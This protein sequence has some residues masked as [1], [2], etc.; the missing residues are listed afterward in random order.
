MKRPLK[1]WPYLTPLILCVILSAGYLTRAQEEEGQESQAQEAAE[2][3]QGSVDAEGQTKGA[4]SGSVRSAV[5]N[6]AELARRES[7][8]GVPLSEPKAIRNPGPGPLPRRAA[9][10]AISEPEAM[11]APPEAPQVASPAPASSFKAL[12]DNGTSVPP[13]THGA[14]GP[15]HLMVTHNTQLRIQTKTGG[16]LS[17]VTLNEFWSGLGATITFD[18]RVLYDPYKKRWMITSV[19]DY[20]SPDAAVLIGVSQTSDPTGSWKLYKVDADSRNN[21]W[22]DY[23]CIGFNRN[24]IVVTV[25]MFTNLRRTFKRTNIYAFDKANLYAFGASANHT[26]FEDTTNGFTMVPAVTYNNTLS[27]LYMVEE[28]DGSSQLRISSLTGTAT[29]PAY[30]TVY[31]FATSRDIWGFRPFGDGE[32]L[33]QLG[34]DRGIQAN[35]SRIQTVIYR[36]GSLW[37]AQTIFLTSETRSRSAVQWWQLSPSGTIQQRGRIDD[38]SGQTFYAYPSLAVNRNRD[39]LIGFSRFSWQQYASANY[40]FRAASD[41]PNT[42]RADVVLKEGSAPYEKS[43]T[44]TANR[45]GDYSST[46]VDPANDLD[47]WTIQEYAAPVSGGT[48]RWGTWWGRIS[49]GPSPPAPDVQLGALAASDTGSDADTVI[50]PG[51][52]ATLNVEL[53]NTGSAAATAVT[54]KLTTTTPG[55]TITTATSVYP[56][57]AATSGAAMNATPFAFEVAS[58]V[59]CGQLLSFTLT[60]TYTGG[61]S[62]R[63]LTFSVPTGNRGTTPVAKSRSGTPV[64]IGEPDTDVNPPVRT[65]VQLAVSGVSGNISDLNFKFGGTQCSA[66]A[67][68]TTVGLDH[69]RVGDLSIRLTSPQGTVVN[70]LSRPGGLNNPGNNFCNTVLDDD[71]TRPSIQSIP[72]TGQGAPYSNTYKPANPLSLFD[73][74]NPNGTWTLTVTDSVHG[75]TGHVRAFSLIITP[76]ECSTATALAAPVEIRSDG[77]QARLSAGEPT[78][79]MSF[80]QQNSLTGK[81]CL[82]A[83]FARREATPVQIGG[84]LLRSASMLHQ[85][86]DLLCLWSEQSRNH[87]ESCF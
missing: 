65:H 75:E 6:F 70:L 30:S 19:A 14:V 76:S 4:R 38:E 17:T 64:E 12:E 25:N 37:C 66:A 9:K 34:S 53:R 73:G 58:S 72:S 63:R 87:R 54:G 23:P 44:G 11:R 40:A 47:M 51:E 7:L 55:V 74:Q 18:P 21:L 1:Y 35:D 33:P 69:T 52:G 10:S 39:V 62:P 32:I 27:T 48:S 86:G 8:R 61:G 82:M 28:W 46:V 80:A 79:K 59:R 49:L 56:D 67:G 78:S 41:P 26:R 85:Y 16:H 24:W 43:L 29:A 83:F 57:L 77:A 36:H 3:V 42:L 81:S 13:D 45:W 31:K 68:S 5:V 84:Q 2:R 60:V 15:Y 20:D 71:T 22:A 50:E